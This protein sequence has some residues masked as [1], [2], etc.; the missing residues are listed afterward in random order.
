MVA[1]ADA[2]ITSLGYS[3]QVQDGEHKN[4]D[5]SII[6]SPCRGLSFRLSHVNTLEGILKSEIGLDGKGADC[7][8]DKPTTQRE[9]VT[10][11][12]NTDISVSEGDLIGRVGAPYVAAWDFWAHKQGY[13]NPGIIAKAY[14]YDVDAICGLDYFVEPIKS[15]IYAKVKRSGEPKCGDIGLDKK[16]TLQGSWF[17]HKDP[18]K[19]RTDWNSH[20]TLAHDSN[21]TS[22]GVLA[23]AGKIADPFIYNFTP[24]HDGVINREP[25]ETTIGTVYC[26]QHS[27]NRRFDNGTFAGEGKVLLKLTDNHTM[28]AQHKDGSCGDNETLS[29]PTTYYR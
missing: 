8:T 3:G 21:D 23:V 28:Q 19:A 10:C 18:E 7:R 16:D 6:L 12:K 15:Q 27:G 14:R 22:I 13:E 20:F 26:Y 24:A 17:A 4:T 5:F 1:P 11:G 9:L 25:S 29:S 2:V